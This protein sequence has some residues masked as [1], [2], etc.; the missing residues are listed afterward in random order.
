[1][2]VLLSSEF[3]LKGH[4]HTAAKNLM[5][6]PAAGEIQVLN[7]KCEDGVTNVCCLTEALR[8]TSC[9]LISAVEVRDQRGVKVLLHRQ[10][11]SEVVCL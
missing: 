8:V 7:P 2:R 1:M 3:L 10:C 6:L 11:F 5:L 4:K 9:Q